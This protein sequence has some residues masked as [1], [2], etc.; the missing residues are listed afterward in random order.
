MNVVIKIFSDI[1]IFFN[2]RKDINTVDVMHHKDKHLFKKFFCREGLKEHDWD[3][4]SNLNELNYRL[5]NNEF[6]HC[7]LETGILLQNVNT[8]FYYFRNLKDFIITLI[9]EQYV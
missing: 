8:G 1:K 2:V 3:A 6:Y 7:A 5:F 9:H 4:P